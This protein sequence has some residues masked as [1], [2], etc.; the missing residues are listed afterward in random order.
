M[1][2][3][4][5]RSIVVAVVA[6]AFAVPALYAGPLLVVDEPVCTPDAILS[7]ASHEWER[8]PDAARFGHQYPNARI[9][10]SVPKQI[11]QYNCHKC[12]ERAQRLYEMGILANRIDLLPDRVDRTYDEA[13]ATRAYMLAHRFTRLL[14]VSSPYH[15]RRALNTFRYVFRGTNV[16]IGTYATGTYPTAQLAKAT[17]DR[18]LLRHYDRIYVEYEWAAIV[19]Y[20][21]KFGVPLV[22][23]WL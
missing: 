20:R 21:F 1:R 12:G 8:L 2:A 11:N 19:Y 7:L 13:T 17:P 22:G 4:T 15:T 23:G 6:L 10:L 9:V 14:V 5:R 3:R 18:W 16:L